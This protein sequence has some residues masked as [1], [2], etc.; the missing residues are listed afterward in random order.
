M[1]KI[2]TLL[3]IILNSTFCVAQNNERR[4][5]LIMGNSNYSVMG[6]L[7]NAQNDATDMTASLQRLGFDVIYGTNLSKKEM[8]EK[9]RL[10][11]EKLK[12][13]DPEKTI[14]LFYYAGHGL[15][16]DGNN[17]L[18]PIDAQME[19]QEDAR[20][21]GIALD[22]ITRRMNYTKNRLNIV[23][24]DACRD[25]PLPKL[26]RD[27]AEGGRGEIT[28]VASGMFIAYGTSPGQKA[29]DS[30]ANGRNGVFT[31]QILNNIEVQGLTLEQ[32]FKKARAGV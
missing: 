28:D 10:F 18:V 17:Y 30:I 3:L 20:D 22:R 23:I 5:A 29:L 19:Y 4:V 14:G 21:E 2:I 31:K 26:N 6:R 27:M 12:A 25:N 9:I 8:T 13:G 32:V 1:K 15:E 11:D 24:L 16:V 7:E